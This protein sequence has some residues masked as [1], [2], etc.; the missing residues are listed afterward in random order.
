M[1]HTTTPEGLRA[2]LQRLDD[3]RTYRQANP[4]KHEMSDVM[5][6]LTLGL[7]PIYKTAKEQAA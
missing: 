3:A 4:L 1:T 5:K 6:W 7:P 2:L